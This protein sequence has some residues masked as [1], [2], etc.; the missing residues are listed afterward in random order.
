M[1]YTLPDTELLKIKPQQEEENFGVFVLEPLSPGYGHTIGNALRRILLS[2]L[3]GAAVTKIRIDGVEHEFSTIQGI[4]EDAVELILNIKGLRV[5][6][7]GDEPTML[8]LDVKGP[9]VIKASSIKPNPSV[10]IVD[11]NYY[12]ATLSSKGHLKIELTV[13]KGRGY[14]PVELRTE[15]K[16][17]IGTLSIDALF[18]PIKLVN[19]RVENTRVGRITNYDKIIL[20]IKTDGTIKPREAFLKATQILQEHTSLVLD[21]ANSLA[22]EVKSLEEVKLRKVKTK[23]VL[24]KEKSK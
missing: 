3:A 17:P 21:L 4:K 7:D 1:P 19:M 12:L 6:Y 22:S 16:N 23:K 8:A 18:S 15:E 11:P 20:E 5:K 9:K 14:L 13:E 24:V 10:E 2:S